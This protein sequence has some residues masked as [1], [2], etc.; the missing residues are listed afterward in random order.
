MKNFYY[1][2][3]AKYPRLRPVMRADAV[4]TPTDDWPFLYIRPGVFPWGYVLILTFV[5]M[6]AFVYVV[7]VFGRGVF[8]SG[9]DPV[10]FFMGAAFLLIETRG[11]TS[12]SL[13]F[14]STWIVNSAIFSGIL[15]MVLMANSIVERY[16]LRSPMLWFV[17]LLLSVILLWA[18][19]P[20]E[21][22]QY[23]LFTRGLLGGLINALPIGFAGILVSMFLK[24]STNP[25]ASLGSNLIGA[26]IGGCL[27]YLS[28]CIGLQALTL[29]ALAFYLLALFSFK[30]REVRL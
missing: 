12:L 15:I 5:M 26:V 29:I 19:K 11:I 23:P 4:Q 6:L 1:D 24:R 18:F 30:R 16:N 7:L 20:T 8:K 28:M 17:F 3:L 9:F 13:L 14:G 27:E 10:L 25:S 2:Y 22:N 21:L